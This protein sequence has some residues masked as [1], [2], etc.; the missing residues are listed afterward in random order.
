MFWQEPRPPF[1]PADSAVV[2]LELSL[3]VVDD[4]PVVE[5]QRAPVHEVGEHLAADVVHL[6]LQ[7]PRRPPHRLPVDPLAVLVEPGDLEIKIIFVLSL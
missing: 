1:G 4:V 3:P 5:A 6:V 2:E 7:Y